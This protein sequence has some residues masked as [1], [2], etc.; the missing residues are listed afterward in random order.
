MR[1]AI[2][3]NHWDID[4]DLDN[5]TYKAHINDRIALIVDFD[6]MHDGGLEIV[7]DVINPD[8]VKPTSREVLVILNTVVSMV[9]HLLGKIEPDYIFYNPTTFSRAKLY[10][11]IMK[12]YLHDIGYA[13][14]DGARIPGLS[15]YK[16]YTRV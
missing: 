7:F 5:F 8:K 1:L 13:F 15:M 11:R 6:L 9:G 12:K 14:D 2:P 3:K 16:I 4:D 10:D